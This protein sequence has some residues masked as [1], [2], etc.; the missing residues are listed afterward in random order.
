MAVDRSHLMADNKVFFFPVIL[1]DVAEAAALVPDKFRERQWS[2]L[3]DDGSTKAFAERIAKLTS[4]R[5]SPGKSAPNTASN[6]EFADL[7][8]TFFEAVS[9]AQAGAQ[10]QPASRE[11][12][13]LDPGLRREES[14][15]SGAANDHAISAPP[16]HKRRNSLLLAAVAA[17]MLV[18][19]TATYLY[20]QRTTALPITSIAV[21]PFQIKG[22]ETD[23][24][25]LTEGLAESLIHRLSQLPKLKVSP[26]SSA[27]R[28]KGNDVDPI[29]V[30]K[31][32]NVHAV[33]TGR[34]LQRGDNFS[35]SVEL[36]DVR[37]KA[38]LWGEKYERK[39]SELLNTQ[40]EMATEI[41]RRLQL[42]LSGEVVKLLAKRYTDNN[43]AYQLYL[44][45]RYL[46]G[47]STKD[48]LARAITFFEQ[49]ITLDPNFALAYVGVAGVYTTTV[50]S[51]YRTA[52]E[53]LPLARA[54]AART[55]E[56]D[57]N[58]ADAHA[59]MA[60]VAGV[61]WQWDEAER[62]FRRALE[63]NPE[64]AEIHRRHAVYSLMPQGRTDEALAELKR[65]LKLDPLSP[66]NS[67]MLIRAYLQVGQKEPALD[68]ARKSYALDAANTA[69]RGWL[70]SA[71]IDSGR[72]D[73]ALAL[74]KDDKGDDVAIF[75][76]AYANVKAGRRDAAMR[77]LAALEAPQ[78]I[79]SDFLA[80]VI[81]AALGNRDAAFAALERAVVA[82]EFAVTTLKV[83]ERFVS[84]RGDARY[85]ALLKRMG[86]AK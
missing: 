30:G 86:L 5:A 54:A 41:T 31:A 42:K 44:Q 64:V 70:A 48:D 38:S 52:N 20:F 73:E 1:G 45:G 19:G 15:M 81:H 8:A 7:A 28:F 78:G 16:P 35:I 59:A 47:K 12:I 53:A 9:P 18:I 67:H 3:N 26:T 32:L 49:A 57:T 63:L 36:I 84:L 61:S 65:A 74:I 55:L 29:K 51:R 68:Q 85:D 43:D 50:F 2:R 4:G 33:M 40:R 69:A 83:D 25:Y 34:I 6:N 66:L 76:R 71:L 75:R 56:I 17:L 13:N 46:T 60:T 79:N 27:F 11:Q 77:E 24:D 39:Q 37:N 80:A 72:Y 58:L 22:N 82:R 21:L 62:G 23:A 10:F 14:R